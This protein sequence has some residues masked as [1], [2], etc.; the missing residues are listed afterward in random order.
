MSIKK[1]VSQTKDKRFLAVLSK[2][3]KADY[4][5]IGG[6]TAQVLAAIYGATAFTSFQVET[7]I[8]L[9]FVVLFGPIIAQVATQFFDDSGTL[10]TRIVILIIVWITLGI[11]AIFV[12]IG[13]YG[14]PVS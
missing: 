7:S 10:A 2:L 8:V 11:A 6:I 1:H 12:N 14:V 9:A 4:V 13:E 3:S 5:T